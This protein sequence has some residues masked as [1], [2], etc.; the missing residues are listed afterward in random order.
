MTPDEIKKNTDI[1]DV[2]GADR[3]LKKVGSEYVCT[4]PWHDDKDPSLTISPK[5]QIYWCPVCD[6]SGDVID[7]VQEYRN[8]TFKEAMRELGDVEIPAPPI[9][10]NAE[11]V[12]HYSDTFYVVRF[13]G[14]KIRPLHYTGAEWVW[15][16]PDKMPLLVMGSGQRVLVEGEKACHAISKTHQGITWHGGSN[17]YKKAI[18]KGISDE[19][20]FWPDNDLPGWVAMQSI[21]LMNGVNPRFAFAPDGA[22]K[23]YDAADGEMGEVKR[24]A[25]ISVVQFKDETR[26]L[27]MVDGDVEV[28]KTPPAEPTTAPSYFE[29][30]GFDK[31][32]MSMYYYFYVRGKNKAVAFTA[33]QLLQKGSLFDLKPDP[34][35]WLKKYGGDKID[36][37]QAATHL[38]QQCQARGLFSMDQIRTRGAWMDEGRTVLHVGKFLIVD[39]QRVSIDEFKSNFTYEWRGSLDYEPGEP[40]ASYQGAEFVEK[41]KLYNWERDVNAELLAGWCVIAPLC[42]ALPWRP[43]IWI[44]GSSGTGKTKLMKDT[45]LP[46]MESIAVTPEGESTEAGIRQHLDGDALPV[47]FDEAE[48]DEK[49]GADRMDGILSLMR[50][51]SSAKTGMILKGS[52]THHAKSYRVRS[53]FGFASIVFSATKKADR[54]R[55]TVLGIRR[56]MDQLKRDTQWN[57]YNEWV[58]NNM[59][60]EWIAGF[61]ARSIRMLPL[62]LEATKI[63]ASQ[64]ALVLK[65]RRLGDQLGTMLAGY[66]MLTHDELPTISEAYRFVNNRDW[67]EETDNDD[68]SDEKQCLRKI[69]QSIVIYE[70][71]GIRKEASVNELVMMATDRDE[72]AE[73]KLGRCGLKVDD[74]ALWVAN[75]SEW[76]KEQLQNTPWSKNYAKILARLDLAE[77]TSPTYFKGGITSRAV[78]IDLSVTR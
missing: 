34:N 47:L 60:D 28:S 10:E 70:D 57:E 17:G 23:G 30:L 64:I 78:K 33:G 12:S 43:H 24:L 59:T 41:L 52:S 66:W 72:W 2:I 40:I 68:E 26:Y 35:Y 29:P 67:S 69:M 74:G 6:K 53:C 3:Q 18:W 75:N 11:L 27:T 77:R 76:V 73:R 36:T 55:I 5:K 7:W 48:Q 16:R 58:T 62:I 14:K 22:K 25:D 61:H 37:E 56:M 1:V 49:R 32:G 42:G 21:A 44:T 46:L 65:D 9:P 39:G 63:F 15:K 38:M 20:I 71:D 51:A 19:V 54:S 4:C 50:S 31:Q 8:K 13:A 45:V